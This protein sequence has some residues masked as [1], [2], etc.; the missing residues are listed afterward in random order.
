M[1][2]KINKEQNYLL[3]EYTS[4]R[5]MLWVHE[6]IKDTGSVIIKKVFRFTGD[7]IFSKDTLDAEDFD[8]GAI[9]ILGTK[10]EDYYRIK[11]RILGLNY[12]LYLAAD[13]GIDDKTF[14]AH[15]DINIFLRINHLVSE[16][17]IIGGNKPNAIPTQEF[18]TLLSKFPTST[19]V[20]H[21]AN[22]RISII[23]KD[24]LETTTDAQ[25]QLRKYLNKK[26]LAHLS[27]KSN[28]TEI[29]PYEIQ[30]YEYLK[31]RIKEA[32][33]EEN[34]YSED[35]WRELILQ[36]ILL[37]FPKYIA[38]LRNVQL[39]DFYSKATKVK[40]R[41]I[42]IVLVDANGNIDIIE[43]KKPF[44]DCLMSRSPYRDNFI[45]KKELAGAIMQAE[46][47]I[48]HLSKWGI[49][50]E[51]AITKKYTKDIPRG[52]QIRITNPKA[53]IILGRT[54]SLS[55]QQI[56]DLEIIKRKYTNMADI[57]TYD[58]LLNRLNNIIEKLRK[59]SK[60]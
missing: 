7:D 33:Q 53:L 34:S 37:I 12:D 44:Q 18:K 27:E 38:V 21:Y 42:D 31:S 41:F 47:Y 29:Y 54:N 8:D 17:I 16:P 60:I 40:R 25:Q 58:D 20:T 56:F 50:G 52:L 28:I 30:K 10:E 46:K 2:I 32:L 11:A 36:F 4:D 49:K 57:I 22:S 23:L 43:I 55:D 13:M 45:P 6:K 1:T 9:F 51:Q 24:Y 14:I 5:G 39:K 48:F 26:P 19:E 15:R 59:N 35:D 3:L